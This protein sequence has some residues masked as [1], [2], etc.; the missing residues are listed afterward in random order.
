M[1]FHLALSATVAALLCRWLRVVLNAFDEAACGAPSSALCGL[2]RC[3]WLLL[4]VWELDP[5]LARRAKNVVQGI[6]RLLLCCDL[7]SYVRAAAARVLGVWRLKVGAL[8]GAAA[9]L[10]GGITL[11]RGLRC[12]HAAHSR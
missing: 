5:T 7:P 11:P 1:P 4:H 8:P 3:M 12:T 6:C 9:D 2:L 10:L